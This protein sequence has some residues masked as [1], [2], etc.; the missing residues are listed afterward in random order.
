MRIRVNGE[1][2]DYTGPPQLDELLALCAPDRRVATLVNDELVT[3]SER[4]QRLLRE[5]D[6]VEVLTL[7]G[8]G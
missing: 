4:P 2:M 8:G 7:A 5:H 3:M 6:R 1:V